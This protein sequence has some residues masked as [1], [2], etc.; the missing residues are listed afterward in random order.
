MLRSMEESMVA[1]PLPFL[2]I[3]GTE[4]MEGDVVVISH[5]Y[6]DGNYKIVFRNSISV[7]LETF[8]NA[9][10]LGNLVVV[11]ITTESPIGS[12]LV[13]AVDIWSMAM[14]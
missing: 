8:S 1:Q 12:T 13:C 7:E 5:V 4:I 10:W 3:F 9:L 6:L 11:P 2:I 14:T